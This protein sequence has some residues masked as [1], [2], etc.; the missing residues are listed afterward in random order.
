MSHLCILAMDEFGGIFTQEEEED[1]D[2]DRLPG[3]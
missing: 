2:E 3:T 1:E